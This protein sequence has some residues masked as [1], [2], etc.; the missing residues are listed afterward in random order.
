MPF[1]PECGGLF[2]AVCPPFLRNQDLWLYEK[3][4]CFSAGSAMSGRKKLTRSIIPVFHLLQP[5]WDRGR[6]GV[7][8]W[9]GG[10]TAR[11]RT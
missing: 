3:H 11:A 10:W 5:L 6:R 9:V 7:G 1:G 2:V 4:R 8:V